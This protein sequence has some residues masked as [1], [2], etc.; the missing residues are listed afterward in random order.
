M[1]KKFLSIIVLLLSCSVSFA[2]EKILVIGDSI[3]AGYGI[4]TKQ[5]WV[6]LLQQRLDKSGYHYQVINA[7]ISGDTTGNGLSRLPIALKQ[8]Q[9]AI[10]VIELGGN[11]GLRGLPA[12]TMY[13]NLTKMT[14]L[15]KN[16][17]ARVLLLGVRLP[18]NYGSVYIQQFAENYTKVAKENKVNLVPLF[19][20][21]ID[22]DTQLM[23][24]DGIH[25]KAE[26]QL[27]L[28]ENVWP[29]LAKL[30]NKK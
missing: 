18:P 6:N 3:S 8:Y 26:A 4:E 27:K 23:Q 1:C 29:N 20:N 30:L 2:A 15:V 21:G 16:A 5:G 9:P 17:N 11:D 19:L 12:E 7:S 13:N 24:S 22:T 14:K 28:L 25:P 10:V